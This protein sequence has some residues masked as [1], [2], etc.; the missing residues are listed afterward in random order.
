V[1]HVTGSSCAPVNG[2]GTQSP[3][4]ACTTENNGRSRHGLV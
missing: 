2:A 4:A 1:A 3:R